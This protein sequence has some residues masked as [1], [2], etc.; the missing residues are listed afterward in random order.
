MEIRII[1]YC[2]L[3]KTKTKE[4][5]E[6]EDARVLQ[7]DVDAV[8]IALEEFLPALMGQAKLLWDK[9]QWKNIEQLFR[10][11][12]EFCHGNEVWKLNLAHTLFMQE[13]FKEAR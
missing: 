11:S 9:G 10:R 13:K 4:L 8:E 6:L 12:A 3:S 5:R 7:K 1:I 2:K